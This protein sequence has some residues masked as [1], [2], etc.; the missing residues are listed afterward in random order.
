M[1]NISCITLPGGFPATSEAE[2]QVVKD[3]AVHLRDESWKVEEYEMCPLVLVIVLDLH[4]N[5]VS[6]MQLQPD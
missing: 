4:T 3:F 6:N 5:R 1:L 2:T